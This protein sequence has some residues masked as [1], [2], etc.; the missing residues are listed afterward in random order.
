[1][2]V[3]LRPVG[4]RHRPIHQ[5]PNGTASASLEKYGGT[6]EELFAAVEE[7][8]LVMHVDLLEILP[9]TLADEH[10]RCG[11]TVV[12]GARALVVLLAGDA[13]PRRGKQFDS[14]L[15]LLPTEDCEVLDE[16]VTGQSGLE[17]ELAHLACQPARGVKPAD[18]PAKISP[19]SASCL[20]MRQM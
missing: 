19:P 16:T 9:V 4:V 18:V 13:A 17:A 3:G 10:H 15:K 5:R 12:A 8:D 14:G 1:M 7:D 11:H 20:V 6:P 2:P